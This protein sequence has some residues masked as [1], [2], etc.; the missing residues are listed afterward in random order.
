MMVEMA[1]S[2][3]VPE[4]NWLKPFTDINAPFVNRMET[5]LRALPFRLRAELVKTICMDAFRN[6]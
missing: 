1:R 2:Q 5:I 3:G 4:L 6:S